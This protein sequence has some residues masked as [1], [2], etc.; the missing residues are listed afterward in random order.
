MSDRVDLDAL[1]AG[2][3]RS[4]I[5]KVVGEL[6]TAFLRSVMEPEGPH[7]R[8]ERC[9]TIEET[10]ARLRVTEDWVR[11]RPDLPFVRKLSDGVVRY[12]ERALDD[13]IA[14]RDATSGRHL[15]VAKR[16]GR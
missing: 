4:D 3:P 15:R 12:C 10:A 9:L 1:F 5:P 16:G 11:R 13:Y 6:V 8:E 2:L 14:G 7:E